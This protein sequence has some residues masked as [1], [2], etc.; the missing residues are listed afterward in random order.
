MNK[1]SKIKTPRPGT[2]TGKPIKYPPVDFSAALEQ[3][4]APHQVQTKRGREEIDFSAA[5][6]KTQPATTSQLPANPS[7]NINN[8]IL[9]EDVVVKEN[10]LNIKD[11]LTEIEINFLEI[12]LGGN[13]SVDNAMIQAGYTNIEKSQRYVLA[14]KIVERY[15]SGARGAKEVMRKCGV[16]EVRVA[17]KID[18]LMEDPSSRTQLGATELAGRILGMTQEQRGPI[19]GIQIIINTAPAAVPGQPGQSPVIDLKVGERKPL[20]PPAKPLQITK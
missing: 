4:Q 3:P 7:S 9:G 16:G 15:E 12:F 20:P 17:K 1:I 13:I 8:I 14:R 5:L 18:G 19:Q 11:Q 6:P 10:H 2:G